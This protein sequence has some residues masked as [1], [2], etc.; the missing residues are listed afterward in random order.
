MS[1][2]FVIF[3][4]F[5]NFNE[6]YDFIEPLLTLIKVKCVEFYSPKDIGSRLNAI[7]ATEG[8]IDNLDREILACASEDRAYVLVTLDKDMINNKALESL[9]K[10]KIL[11]PKDLL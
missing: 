6:R 9:L 3:Q 4:S 8:R 10:I 2:L 11:H 7:K 1:E 5:E